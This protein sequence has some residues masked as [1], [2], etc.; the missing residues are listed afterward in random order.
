[1]DIS[2][3]ALILYLGLMGLKSKEIHEDMVVTLEE[4]APS[5]NVVKK[6]DAEFKRGKDSLEG[7]PIQ[8]GQSPSPH[9]RPL[10]KFMTWQ[11]DE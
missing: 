10:P 5:H 9:K 3:R 4:N 6:W 2:H 11:T 8:E 7:D 1:M